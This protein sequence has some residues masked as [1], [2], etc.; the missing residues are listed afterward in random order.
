[1]E[2]PWKQNLEIHGLS[3]VSIR[4]KIVFHKED[5]KLCCLGEMGESWPGGGLMG[6][7]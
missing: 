5:E 2:A 7:G 3:C 6:I 1:M 4:L